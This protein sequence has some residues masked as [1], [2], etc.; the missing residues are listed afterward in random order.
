MRTSRLIDAL[1]SRLD[2]PPDACMTAARKALRHVELWAVHDDAAVASALHGLAVEVFDACDPSYAPQ[3]DLVSFVAAVEMMPRWFRRVAAPRLSATAAGVLAS[4]DDP[5]AAGASRLDVEVYMFWD[6]LR[7][8]YEADP[9]E[10]SMRSATSSAARVA[11]AVARACQE[12]LRVPNEVVQVGALH[13]LGH[14]ERDRPG[15]AAPIVA[16]YLSARPNLS[17]LLRDYAR[18]ALVGDV[19]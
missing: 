9:D 6:L 7:S 17:P 16:A 13:G 3:A 10:T 11:S 18:R 19:Q 5:S 2:I 4:R 8:V 12:Q 1:T 15:L 14:V